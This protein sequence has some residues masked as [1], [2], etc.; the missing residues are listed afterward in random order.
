MHSVL[1][2]SFELFKSL[3]EVGTLYLQI[4]GKMICKTICENL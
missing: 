4:A 1:P 2:T 3:Y